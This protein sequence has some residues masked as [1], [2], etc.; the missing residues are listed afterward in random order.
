M[1][2]TTRLAQATDEEAVFALLPQLLDAP[3]EGRDVFRALLSS[4]R[5]AVVVVEEEGRLLGFIS[6][7]FNPAIRYG[8]NYAQIEELIVDEAARGKQGGAILVRAAI[9]EARKRGC[10]EIGLYSREHTRAFYEKLGFAYSGPEL[11]QRLD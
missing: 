4:D 10:R 2:V 3:P 8:G 5:G 11:R 6:L 9:A 1:A 7:S